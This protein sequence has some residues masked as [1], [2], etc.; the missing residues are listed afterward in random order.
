[1]NMASVAKK[2]AS[3]PI[4]ARLKLISIFFIYETVLEGRGSLNQEQ[5]LN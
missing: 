4:R 5:L 3:F 2:E 1:M